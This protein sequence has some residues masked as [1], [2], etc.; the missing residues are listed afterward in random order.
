MSAVCLEFECT[1][2][3]FGLLLELGEILGTLLPAS[4]DLSLDI[5]GSFRDVATMGA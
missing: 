2:E 4:G 1:Q 3:I 5:T